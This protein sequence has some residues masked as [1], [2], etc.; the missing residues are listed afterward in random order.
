MLVFVL[1]SRFD[2]LVEPKQGAGFISSRPHGS[3]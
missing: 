2:E 3:H 1:G